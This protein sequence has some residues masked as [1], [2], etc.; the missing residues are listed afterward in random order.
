MIGPLFSSLLALLAAQ[1]PSP[2]VTGDIGPIIHS[3]CVPCHR[4]G[5]DAPFSL[6]TIDDVRRRASM[7]VAVTKSRYMPPWKPV[8]GHGNFRGSRRLTDIEIATIEQWVSGGMKAPVTFAGASGFRR[9]VPEPDLILQLPSYTLRADGGDVFR[10]FVVPIPSTGIRFVRGLEFRPR[11][12]AVHHAN[13]RIDATAASRRLDDTDPLPGYEGVIA[14]SADFPDGHFLGWTPGQLAPELDDDTAWRLQ[15]GSDLVVQLHLRPTGAT[16]SIAPVVEIFF[17]DRAAAHT[18]TMIRLGRQDLDIPAGA[19][20]HPVS[21]SFVLPVAVE[22]R[23][24]QAHAHYRARS[25]DTYATLP[26][27]STT[28]LLRIDDWDVNWQDR[29]SYAKPVRLPAGT[30]LTA[31]YIFDNSSSNPRNPDRP[32]LRTRWGWRTSDEMADVWI[33]VLTASDGDRSKLRAAIT[34]K[35]LREDAIGAEVLLE[36]E[37]DHV[38]LRNDAAQ[39]YMALGQPAK[40]LAHFEAVTRLQ[41]NVAAAW[42]N[43]GTAFEALGRRDDARAKYAHAIE[44]DPKY[45]VAL[46]NSGALLLREGRIADARTL[47]ERAVTADRLNADAHANLGL[48]LI[49]GGDA[50]GGLARVEQAIAIRPELLA[51]MAPHVW[52]LAAH[53]DGSIRRPA[54]ALRLAERIAAVSR[55]RAGALDLLAACQAATGAFDQAVQTAS[56]ALTAAPASSTDLGRAIRARLARYRNRQPFV[57]ER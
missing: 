54:A 16:E 20:G 45:S 38:H 21:D 42:Y 35:M 13:I 4:A 12:G 46:N 18:P 56:A 15:P 17:G 26:D 48:A 2:P 40:A 41:P 34:P 31:T 27:G 50:D 57:L 23:A 47:F 9:M 8:P 22:A 51:G 6:E 37:P 30:R 14:R 1:A 44:L 33:Q 55:D 19:S 10:N 25:V 53:A 52:L 43:E 5:G 3:R 36:R 29:Y 32:P 24:I 39:I 49:A 11:S 7:I 28:P